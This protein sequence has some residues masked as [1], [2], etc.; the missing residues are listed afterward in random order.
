MVLKGF[1]TEA[2]GVEGRLRSLLTKMEDDVARLRGLL[3]Q[4][5]EKAS[6]S[7]CKTLEVATEAVEAF[8]NGE[9][10]Y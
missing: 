6:H 4:I 10:F 2:K 5:K 1:L 3:A 9:G 7:E 8:K